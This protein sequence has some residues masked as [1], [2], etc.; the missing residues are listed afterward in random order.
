MRKKAYLGIQGTYQYV[1]FSDENK[2]FIPGG[3]GTEH[4]DK[5]IEG[6]FL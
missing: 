4:L 6:D 5:N 2:S 3:G 1:N